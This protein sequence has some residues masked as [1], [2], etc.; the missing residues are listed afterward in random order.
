MGELQQRANIK[1]P[2]VKDIKDVAFVDVLGRLT[3]YVHAVDESKALD[4]SNL[5]RVTT[6]IFNSQI[7]QN[8]RAANKPQMLVRTQDSD[9]RSTDHVFL[10]H[11]NS[12]MLSCRKVKL[13]VHDRFYTLKS[14]VV[15][16]LY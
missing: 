4:S 8:E 1:I 16:L 13:R 10:V 15:A 9:L 5:A 12:I 7:G 11:P 6:I 14:I 3:D 2:K